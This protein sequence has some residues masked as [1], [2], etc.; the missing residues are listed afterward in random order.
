MVKWNS[1]SFF[2]LFSIILVLT[3]L[4]VYGII[5]MHAGNMT[6]ILKENINILVEMKQDISE[7]EVNQLIA[8][9]KKIEEIKP[10]SVS[11]IPKSDALEQMNNEL[12]EEYLL[13]E[14]DNPFSDIVI[15]NVNYEYVDDESLKHVKG[16]V[17][18][19]SG[20]F[21]VNYYESVYE[22]LGSNLRRISAVLFILGIILSV[23]AF[24]LIYSTIQLSMYADRFKIRTMELVGAKWS[25]IRKPFIIKAIR[26]ALVSSFISVIILCLLLAILAFQFENF[27]RVVNLFY[28]FLVFILITLIA[29]L[30][31]QLASYIVVNR[32]LGASKS[33]FY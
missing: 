11:Y 16:K 31:T 21:A 10:E 15:F 30:I 20:V 9:L 33:K 23:F 25:Q 18:Q 22:Y 5:T 7:S 13:N 28:V 29:F 1:S 2:T 4:G 24:S 27:F 14:L 8:E 6:D 17:E 26:M 3:L 12:G 19:L 32:Y